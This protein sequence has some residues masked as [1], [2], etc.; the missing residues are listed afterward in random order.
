MTKRLLIGLA[1]ALALLLVLMFHFTRSPELSQVERVR[2]LAKESRKREL[3]PN[4]YGQTSRPQQ[5]R[6]FVPPWERNI[7]KRAPKIDSSQLA[8]LADGWRL[9]DEGEFVAARRRF[10]ALINEHGGEPGIPYAF[11]A[12]SEA[13][14]LEGDDE[15]LRAAYDGFR[16][17]LVFYPNH[18]LAAHA[19]ARVVELKQMLPP[20]QVPV[21]AR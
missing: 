5:T 16:D 7:E 9:V 20:K 11:L 4:T 18:D 8:W 12:I 17:F 3:H 19:S 2:K 10:Q 21:D 14:A 1:I 6:R 15:N 13:F